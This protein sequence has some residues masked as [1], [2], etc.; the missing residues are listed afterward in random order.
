MPRVQ[1]SIDLTGMWVDH[2]GVNVQISQQGNE[3]VS[4]AY[5]PLTGLSINAVWQVSGRRIAFNWASNAGN[6]GY[7][8]G[9]SRPTAPPSTTS[10]LTMSPASRAT[11]GCSAC[12]SSRR[13]LQPGEDTVLCIPYVSC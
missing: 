2:E 1:K 6:Q 5:N 9:R 7:G 10:L 13:T 4:Q 3:V 8:K 12:P 11:A